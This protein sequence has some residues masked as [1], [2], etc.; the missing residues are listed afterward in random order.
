[1]HGR[2]SY[3]RDD[4]ENPQIHGFDERERGKQ[5]GDE[6]ARERGADAAIRG[7]E[8]EREHGKQ[9]EQP[10]ETLCV[11]RVDK[12]IVRSFVVEIR[13]SARHGDGLDFSEFDGE[14]FRAGAQ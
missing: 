13:V 3:N 10:G 8:A 6:D 4:H 9:D 2:F 1:M 7:R 14:G 5:G 11:G 12:S